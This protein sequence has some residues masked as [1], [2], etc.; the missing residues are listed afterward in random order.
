MNAKKA[1]NARFK[2]NNDIKQKFVAFYQHYNHEINSNAS[3]TQIAKKFIET[4]SKCLEIWKDTEAAQ[5][6]L[7]DHL[8]KKV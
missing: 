2:T 6:N 4:N 5:R 3:K 7:L 8:R 1:V